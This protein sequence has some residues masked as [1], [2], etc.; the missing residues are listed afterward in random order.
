MEVRGGVGGAEKSQYAVKNTERSK[1]H[2]NL[3]TSTYTHTGGE[4]SELSIP[5]F[6]QELKRFFS[7]MFCFCFVVFFFPFYVDGVRT[8]SKGPKQIKKF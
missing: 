4:F 2:A 1:S 3:Y 8:E 5:N 7:P 6:I